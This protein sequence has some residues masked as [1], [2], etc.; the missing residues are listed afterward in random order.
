MIFKIAYSIERKLEPRGEKGKNWNLKHS[1]WVWQ[2]ISGKKRE[3]VKMEAGP[4]EFWKWHTRREEKEKVENARKLKKCRW[5]ARKSK[6]L[7]LHSRYGS[8]SSEQRAGRTKGLE[9]AVLS[10]PV[11]KAFYPLLASGSAAATCDSAK[12][13]LMFSAHPKAFLG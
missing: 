4:K 13:L 11:S 5:R 6:M 8:T 12:T 7:S 1:K 2:Q 3:W 10:P 9:R